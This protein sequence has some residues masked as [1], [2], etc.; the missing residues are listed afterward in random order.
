MWT[1]KTNDISSILL[2]SD[3]NETTGTAATA[4]RDKAAEAKIWNFMMIMSWRWFASLALAFEGFWIIYESILSN[5]LPMLLVLSSLQLLTRVGYIGEDVDLILSTLN[6]CQP[7][8]LLHHT[9]YSYSFGTNLRKWVTFLP[10][11]NACQSFWWRCGLYVGCWCVRSVL[12]M[13]IHTTYMYP[14]WTQST[15]L[16]PSDVTVLES[17]R[18]SVLQ[19]IVA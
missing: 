19:Y 8:H 17:E 9:L 18:W 16:E 11:L 15:Y 5:I 6:A 2:T 14:F 10:S 3:S 7:L 4:S 12:C 1:R 13:Y